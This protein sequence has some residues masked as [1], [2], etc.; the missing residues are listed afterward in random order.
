MHYDDWGEVKL[1]SDKALPPFPVCFL[2]RKCS[3]HPLVYWRA[4]P[5][6]NVSSTQRLL[7]FL[8]KLYRVPELISWARALWNDFISDCNCKAI[9]CWFMHFDI[10]SGRFRQSKWTHSDCDIK[11]HLTQPPNLRAFSLV[12]WCPVCEF[13]LS[14]FPFL[15][16]AF[17]L[18]ENA[19]VARGL[20]QWM[21]KE[22]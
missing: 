22:I 5:T 18:L 8:T 21:K 14:C 12:A 2:S 19:S 10:N 15:R 20:D 17:S 13:A 11:L 1:S 6:C 7:I 3:S 16:F 9:S 4:Y